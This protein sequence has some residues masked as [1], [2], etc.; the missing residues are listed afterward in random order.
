M[1]ISITIIILE[2]D[3]ENQEELKEKYDALNK[4]Y[5]RRIIEIDDL[6]DVVSCLSEFLCKMNNN[7]N[8]CSSEASDLLNIIDDEFDKILDMKNKYDK[9][10]DNVDDLKYIMKKF[11]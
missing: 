9:M 7:K 2:M 11:D 5:S 6:N 10:K 4:D 3:I 1:I 8:F